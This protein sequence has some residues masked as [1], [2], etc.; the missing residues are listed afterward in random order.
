MGEL[1][2]TQ[3]TRGADLLAIGFGTTV[4]MW[5]IGYFSRVSPAAMPSRVLLAVMLACL[6]G[7]GFV[8]GRYT[9][10]GWL[11]GL[12]TGALAGALNLLVLGSL[13]GGDQP[14][15]VVPSALWWVPG[16][17]LVA[18]MAGAVGAAVGTR[19]HAGRAK[20]VNWTSAFAGVAAAATLILLTVGAMVT[21]KQAGLSVPDWPNTFGYNMFFYPLSRMT[22]GIYYEHGHRLFGTLVGLTTVVLAVHLWVTDRR[23][24]IRVAA[25]VAVVAVIAQGILGGLR[26]TG[27]FTLSTS[28][29]DMAPNITI[30]MVH[31][32]LGQLFFA[33]L[34]AVTVATSATWEAGRSPAAVSAAATD[35]S[36]TV[37]LVALLVLQLILGVILRHKYGAMVIH[38]SMAVLVTVVAVAVGLRSWGL[39]D[40]RIIQRLGLTLILLTCLQVL[41]GVGALTATGATAFVRP[42]PAPEV[43]L[44]TAHQ[45]VGAVL[46]GWAVMLLLWHRR[47]FVGK[48]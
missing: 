36:L 23:R 16:S 24:A 2:E 29:A 12:G 40:E 6:V 5:C 33:L 7:G 15:Q 42:P 46:L 20:P 1:A 21:S 11:G 17:I 9:G 35:R 22:G 38:I 44:A 14:N 27:H 3:R 28:H 41:L 47:L 10:R 37:L 30:A 19:W 32:V 8:A 45:V 31:G 18:A 25:A 4:A 39:Y 13:L 48:V 43:V 26:V 34:V